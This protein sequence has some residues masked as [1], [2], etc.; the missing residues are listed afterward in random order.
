MINTN[1]FLPVALKYFNGISFHLERYSLTIITPPPPPPPQFYKD[2]QSMM[3]G[4]CLKLKPTNV[5]F[6]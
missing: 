3:S 1:Q 5:F 2:P 6:T 4:I